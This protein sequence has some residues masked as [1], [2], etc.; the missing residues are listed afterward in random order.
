MRPTLLGVGIGIAAAISLSQVLATLIYGVQPTDT[1]TFVA[2]AALLT[3]VGLLASIIPAYR[4][5][6]VDPVR[7]LRDE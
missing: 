2:V 4:A 3:M 7:T 5:T 6:R 1:T